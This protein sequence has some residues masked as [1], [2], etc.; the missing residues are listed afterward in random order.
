M[1]VLE[2]FPVENKS[3]PS[4]IWF[5]QTNP[6][7][8]SAFCIPREPQRFI[9]CRTMRTEYDLPVTACL[10][11]IKRYAPE[12]LKITSDGQ[13]LDWEPAVI[14]LRRVLGYRPEHFSA[15]ELD[16]LE[17]LDLEG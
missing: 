14:F 1:E 7:E 11:V 3:T 5:D 12:W 13:W 17:L 6:T 8:H 16:F 9:Y 10:L 15:A 2:H 4:K